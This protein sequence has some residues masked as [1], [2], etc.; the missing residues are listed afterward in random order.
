MAKIQFRETK[1]RAESLAR[2][3]QMVEIV[4]EY[5]TAGLKLTA[6]QLYYQ[7]VSRGY[8]ENKVQSYKNLTSLLTDA[9]YAGLID[10]EAIEDRGRQP[11]TPSEWDSI[12]ALVRTAVRSYRLPRWEGQPCYAELWVEKQ[13]LAGVLEPMAREFHV[14]LSVNKGYSSASA[15]FEAAQRFQRN[16]NEGYPN[17]L[18]YLGDHDPSG[19]D[20]VRDIEDR[21]NEFGVEELRV[22]KIALTMEQVRKFRPPPNPAKT[23]DSRFE[24]YEAKHGKQSWEVDALPPDELQRLI[25]VAFEDVIDRE[26][27]DAVIAREERGKRA[28]QRAANNIVD[29]E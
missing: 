10:W 16:G 14:T 7:F 17:Y 25:R 13:A 20:M 28:L 3:Q 27:M 1:F 4:D 15:M 29:E 21:L 8:I 24:A 2:I 19:E 9:R 23:T 5:A 12:Q 18:F 22:E 26:A 11:D 6:R